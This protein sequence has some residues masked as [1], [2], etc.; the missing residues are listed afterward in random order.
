MTGGGSP[1]PGHGLTTASA[2]TE[3]S[4]L[5]GSTP[6]HATSDTSEVSHLDSFFQGSGWT[7]ED[8]LVAVSVVELALWAILLYLEVTHGR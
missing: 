8:V 5:G 1:A 6:L 2:A 3:Q 7:R 4:S